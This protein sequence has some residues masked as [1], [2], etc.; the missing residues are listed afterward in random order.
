M[1]YATAVLKNLTIQREFASAYGGL[2]VDA[3]GNGLLVSFPSAGKAVHCALAIQSEISAYGR[4]DA[5][6][7]SLQIGIHAASLMPDGKVDPGSLN[8]AMRI[9]S[10]AEPGSVVISEPIQQQLPKSHIQVRA[11]KSAM[12]VKLFIVESSAVDPQDGE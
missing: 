12:P 1:Q 3:V 6:V 10:R 9:C 11:R 4:A 7:P 8:I 5:P 2:E